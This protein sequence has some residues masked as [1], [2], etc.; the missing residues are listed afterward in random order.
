MKKILCF[1]DSNTFGF[2]PKNGTRFDKNIRW[3]GVLQNL[4]TENFQIVE[5]GCNNRTAFSVNPSGKNFTGN[6]ILPELL[7]DNF[8]YVILSVGINDLQNQ[9]DVSEKDIEIGI[10]NLIE[11]VRLTL[12]D[13][14]IIL[15]S[16]PALTKNVLK[17]PFFSTLFNEKSIEKSKKLAKIYE[18]IAQKTGSDFIDLN[19]I[20]TPS[21]ADGLHFEEEE[22]K[23]I[24]TEIFLHLK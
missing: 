19:K 11:I 7:N 3:T 9:Y 5:N 15:I 8:E 1:G 22:H 16:P 21:T 14:K 12:P 20:A 18:R 13:T 17:S 23:K 2:N 10:T 6:K 24:A 4:C